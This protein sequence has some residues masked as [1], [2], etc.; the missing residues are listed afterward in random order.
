MNRALSIGTA[1]LALSAC[2]SLTSD[3]TSGPNVHAPLW[4][5]Y[6][7]IS[8]DGH[9]DA[10][11]TDRNFRDYRGA[12]KIQITALEYWSGEMDWAHIT[13]DSCFRYEKY[14]AKR[15][16]LPGCDREEMISA[17]EVLN[18]KSTIENMERVANKIDKVVKSSKTDISLVSDAGLEIAKFRFDKVAE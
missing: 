16:E 8:L 17:D 2:G 10:L 9:E 5:E 15:V 1:A 12:G 14:G 6:Q 3:E 7:L 4:H 18:P 13:L 11:L